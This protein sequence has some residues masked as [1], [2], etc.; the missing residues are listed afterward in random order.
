M[1]RRKIVIGLGL[2]AVAAFAS[3]AALYGR[4]RGTEPTLI[5]ADPRGLVRPHSPVI[6]PR[7]ARVTIVEF[8]D[9]AC[10]ACRAMHPSVKNILSRFPN[11]VRLVIRYAAFHQ[12]SDE[13]VRILE[14]ARL[15]GRFEA[16]LEALLAGQDDWAS[17]GSPNLSRA[18]QIAGSVGLDSPRAQRDG[19]SAA[20]ASAIEEDTADVRRHMI[21]GTPTFFVNGRQLETLGPQQLLNLVSEEVQRSRASGQ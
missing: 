3:A 7:D 8:F 4:V 13:A 17:H 20:I 2:F 19:R 21:R 11:D 1:N 6:G 9:P 16:V 15:Q 10:E 14:A 18:W 5:A 12:G